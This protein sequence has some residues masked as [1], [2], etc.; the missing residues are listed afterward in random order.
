MKTTVDLDEKKLK[1]LMKL[2]GFRTKKETINFALA[3]AERIA[4]LENMLSGSFYISKSGDVVY[5]NYDI[6]KMR[7]SADPRQASR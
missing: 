2:T 5:P 7:E 6:L 1:S 4:R 3:Q